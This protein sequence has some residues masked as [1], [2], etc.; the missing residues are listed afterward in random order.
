MNSTIKWSLAIVGIIGF[1]IL[2]SAILYQQNP[3]Q[4][5]GPCDKPTVIFSE[6]KEE[7]NTGI[8]TTEIIEY[9]RTENCSNSWGF[10][11]LYLLDN[12]GNIYHETVYPI[13]NYEGGNQHHINITSAIANDTKG[14]EYP[15]RIMNEM[16]GL[17]ESYRDSSNNS[18]GFDQS[19]KMSVGDTIMIY[20][21]GD[22]A[23]GPAKQGWSLRIMYDRTAENLTENLVIP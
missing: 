3:V 7:N 6:L 17:Y 20:G 5:F 8:Y 23:D 21:S 19:M 4:A 9:E 1:T 10:I 12:Q 11:I 22:K 16:N 18:R 14:A 13:A 15:V 2:L